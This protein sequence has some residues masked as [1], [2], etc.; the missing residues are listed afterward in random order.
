MDTFMSNQNKLDTYFTLTHLNRSKDELN[1][2]M[3]F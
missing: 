2:G 3:H 1:N